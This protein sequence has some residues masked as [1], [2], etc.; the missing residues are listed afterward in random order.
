MF[1]RFS[2]SSS[3]HLPRSLFQPVPHPA[4][5]CP[6]LLTCESCPLLFNRYSNYNN[7]SQH[8]HNEEEEEATGAD[9]ATKKAIEEAEVTGSAAASSEEATIAQKLE[10]A[11]MTNILPKLVPP[12]ESSDNENTD[13]LSCHDSGIDIRDPAI[14]QQLLPQLQANKLP[15]APPKKYSDA[16]IVLSDDW[17]PPIPLATPLGG[18]PSHLSTDPHAGD[19]KKT[20]SV[21]FSVDEAEPQQVLHDKSGADKKNKA[22]F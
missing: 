12:T 8:S 21:S 20:S 7:V 9:D 5:C 15:Q 3:Q 16:D 6:S 4:L 18:G 17:V 22:S 13:K 14:L 10:E 19:R 11:I 1:Y 2:Q